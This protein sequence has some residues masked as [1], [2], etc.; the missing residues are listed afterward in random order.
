MKQNINKSMKTYLQDIDL[1]SF[2]IHNDVKPV[3]F[4]RFI[5]T[6]KNNIY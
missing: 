3:V 6:W 1:E 5:R 2:S 4:D